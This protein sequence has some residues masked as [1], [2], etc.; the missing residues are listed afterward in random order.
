LNARTAVSI[1]MMVG[2]TRSSALASEGAVVAIV[3]VIAVANSAIRAWR[4]GA[5]G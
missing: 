1:V 4:F 2:S 5:A 3:A